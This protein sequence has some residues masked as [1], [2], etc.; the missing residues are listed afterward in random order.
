MAWDVSGNYVVTGP[1]DICS[2]I[3][4]QIWPGHLILMSSASKMHVLLNAKML[5][6]QCRLV[7]LGP[8]LHP[9]H[10]PIHQSLNT[11]DR[12][13]RDS[14]TLLSYR[15]GRGNSSSRRGT[16]LATRC[17]SRTRS[18]RTAAS[19]TVAHENDT[20]DIPFEASYTMVPHP[21]QPSIVP[22]TQPHVPALP[23]VE[24]PTRHYPLVMNPPPPSVEPFI[25]HPPITTLSQQSLASEADEF[26]EYMPTTSD[27]E[28]F[29]GLDSQLQHYSHS[30]HDDD[31]QSPS[32]TSA[33]A[34]RY[35]QAGYIAD[36]STNGHA[37]P[38]GHTNKPLQ[39]P[40]PAPLTSANTYS[41]SSRIDSSPMRGISAPPDNGDVFMSH[42]HTGA[43]LPPLLSHHMNPVLAVAPAP[44]ES[45][46]AN[47]EPPERAGGRGGSAPPTP[48]SQRRA[49]PLSVSRPPHPV[50]LGIP[51][52]LASLVFS[53]PIPGP[54]ASA[55]SL[56]ATVT[57]PET[58]HIQIEPPSSGNH[59][60]AIAVDSL[61][62]PDLLGDGQHPPS[63]PPPRARPLQPYSPLPP[64]SLLP[65]SPGSDV[66]SNLPDATLAIPVANHAQEPIVN[67]AA[68]TVAE[69]EAFPAAEHDEHGGTN[70]DDIKDDEP[71]YTIDAKQLQDQLCDAQ[72]EERRVAGE[73]LQR[74]TQKCWT[75]DI[76]FHDIAAS[77][78]GV[79]SEQVQRLW[80]SLHTDAR[81]HVNIWGL[82]QMLHS[83]RT[84]AECARLGPNDDDSATVA[85]RKRMF[86]KFTGKLVQS[87]D[88]A[89]VRWGFESILLTSG[90]NPPQDDNVRFMYE[91]EGAAGFV[92]W[93]TKMDPDTIIGLLRSHASHLSANLIIERTHK[94]ANLAAGTSSKAPADV[95]KRTSEPSGGSQDVSQAIPNADALTTYLVLLNYPEDVP[96]PGHPNMDRSKGIAALHGPERERLARA[97][98]H[99]TY[100]LKFVADYEED[101]NRHGDYIVIVGVPPAASSKHSHGLRVFWSSSLEA[102]WTDY[103]GPPRRVDDDISPANSPKAKD[104]TGNI[105]EDDAHPK[106]PSPP[107]AKRTR[108]GGVAKMRVVEVQSQS[109]DQPRLPSEDDND[110]DSYHDSEEEMRG[111]KRVKF[112]ENSPSPFPAPSPAPSLAPSPAPSLAPSPAPS[113]T[114]VPETLPAMD[115]QDTAPSLELGDTLQLPS[116]KPF[117]RCRPPGAPKPI[118]SK[119]KSPIPSG[120]CAPLPA[121]LHVAPPKTSRVPP[122]S[123]LRAP[124]LTGPRAPPP[125]FGPGQMYVTTSEED[126][127]EFVGMRKLP[128]APPQWSPDFEVV[129]D[130]SVPV[131]TAKRAA[132]KKGKGTKRGPDIE[133]VNNAPSRAK[134]EKPSAPKKSRLMLQ[135]S[136]VELVDAPPMPPRGPGLPRVVITKRPKMTQEQQTRMK[137]HVKERLSRYSR[138]D[139][140]GPAESTGV[141]AGP[142]SKHQPGVVLRGM[143]EPMTSA[144]PVAG[145]NRS[146]PTPHHNEGVHKLEQTEKHVTLSTQSQG[147]HTMASFGEPPSYPSANQEIPDSRRDYLE[148]QAQIRKTHKPAA[149]VIRSHIT[150]KVIP[151]VS[152]STARTISPAPGP[153]NSNPPAP[154][155][156]GPTMPAPA[157]LIPP[158][159]AALQMAAMPQLNLGQI[160]SVQISAEV[161]A[162]ALALQRQLQEQQQQNNATQR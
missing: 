68:A 153:S 156:P 105:A 22:P 41:K 148:L 40:L 152:S 89:H 74:L 15:M 136:D 108:T 24:Y 142:S 94:A 12:L 5:G 73:L 78:P 124:P 44:P 92:E 159:P 121:S 146:R 72:V 98:E 58:L 10:H 106:A 112:M 19:D 14:D 116:Q 115:I 87:L 77:K 75:I 56:P 50:G 93:V 55:A 30:V 33:M 46:S 37:S 66:A 126:Y 28:H 134:G 17:S 103:K 67:D 158:D 54:A 23:P 143:P 59:L 140:K 39:I 131:K 76:M 95:A 47:P 113:G 83:D 130:L 123:T 96:Y 65:P 45:L 48:Q 32:P 104:E 49:A 86:H 82:Y 51:S 11:Y 122:P 117:P 119:S 110:D 38:D 128:G 62:F 138:D 35:S 101:R 84:A 118:T 36:L 43:R 114:P 64:S 141:A 133:P 155:P 129:D 111:S 80:T 109:D 145:P 3:G 7:F 2:L 147:D 97:L 79:T 42:H 57:A 137:Q 9:T 150:G 91:T 16:G 132:A 102:P 26:N 20:L 160:G 120:S 81:Q 52:L 107:V 99:P 135:D 144:A 63:T 13:K 60:G 1:S 34:T 139:A 157:P 27:L 69:H 53:T 125:I 18:A 100:P 6:L 61:I 162:L 70:L 154:A 127:V 31:L 8:I 25:E 29:D 90:N 151:A 149:R 71:D 21:I 161:I 85:S 88:T 4:I